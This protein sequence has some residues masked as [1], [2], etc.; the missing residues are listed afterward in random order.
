MKK[1]SNKITADEA[2]SP[3][4]DQ[5]KT[6]VAYTPMEIDMALSD[7]PVLATSL[8]A[9]YTALNKMNYLVIK[10]GNEN[11][12]ELCS[13]QLFFTGYSL[14]GIAAFSGMLRYLHLFPNVLPRIHDTLSSIA[15][16]VGF[17]LICF[18]YFFFLQPEHQ[19]QISFG[20][21]S[22]SN[23]HTFQIM[24]NLFFFLAW[25]LSKAASV[26]I[27]KDL[28]SSIPAIIVLF[29]AYSQKSAFASFAILL[30]AFAARVGT[31]SISNGVPAVIVFHTLIS[32]ANVFFVVSW[33]NA[34][35]L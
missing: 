6:R 20:L 25:I 15:T 22:R 33:K 8:W 21:F 23:A 34:F 11:S 1:R 10:H 12:P 17:P 7:L 3:T 26:L 32:I 4:G 28:S 27:W 13:S 16:Q 5:K 18:S 35:L 24:I 29:F 2:K 19:H 9:V 30:Y 31:T 14:I